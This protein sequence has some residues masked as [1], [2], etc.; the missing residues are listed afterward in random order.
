MPGCSSPSISDRLR[1]AAPWAA[2]AFALAGC[3]GSSRIPQPTAKHVELAGRNGQVTTLEAL[4]VGRSLYIGRCGACHS[5]KDPGFLDPGDWPGMVERMTENAKLSPDQQR[6]ITQY[7]VGVSAAMHGD[8]A[9]AAPAPADS[10][11]APHS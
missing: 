2:A 1:A 5:L 3:A 7:L 9:S 10:A 4:K 8:S 11:H 6:A